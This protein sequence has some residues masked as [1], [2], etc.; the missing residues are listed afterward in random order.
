MCVHE[1]ICICTYIRRKEHRSASRH[2]MVYLFMLNEELHFREVCISGESNFRVLRFTRSGTLSTADR[3]YMATVRNTTAVVKIYY[4][5]L[6]LLVV[7]IRPPRK[8]S[9][10]QRLSLANRLPTLYGVALER[11]TENVPRKMDVL[12]ARVQPH[13]VSFFLR[14]RNFNFNDSNSKGFQSILLKISSYK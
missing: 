2:R 8:T 4:P 10:H 11:L 3:C 12:N 14:N 9:R 7:P 6:N 1:F 5:P 13:G